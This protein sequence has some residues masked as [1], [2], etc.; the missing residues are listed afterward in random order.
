MLSV[1]NSATRLTA[2]APDRALLPVPEGTATRWLGWLVALCAVVAG[3]HAMSPSPVGVFYDDAMYVALGKAIAHG[4]GYAYANLP[5]APAAT[6]YPPIYPL[7]L[8]LLWRIAPNFPAN[9]VLFKLANVAFTAFAAVGAYVFGRR[10]LR[11]PAALAAL[12]AIVGAVALP[13]LYLT[14][15]VLSEPMFLALLIPVLLVSERMIEHEASLGHAFAVGAAIGALALVRTFGVLVAPALVVALVA[16]YRWRDALSMTL[17]AALVLAPWV[18][19]VHR[20][21]AL[22]P[23]VL[24]GAYGSYTGWLIE[25]TRSGGLEFVRRTVALNALTTWGIIARTFSPWPSPLLD[26]L[27]VTLLAALAVAGAVV[28]RRRVRVTL[29][30][31][32][33]YFAI[34]LIW[35]FPPIRFVANLWALLILLPI[36]GA[37]ALWRLAASRADKS[38]LRFLPA[39]AGGVVALGLLVLTVQGYGQS[40]WAGLA[41]F[42]GERIDPKTAWVARHTRSDDVIA[43]EDEVAVYLYT[44]RHAVPVY[45]SPGRQHIVPQTPAER[46]QAL[47]A[48]I[49]RYRPSFIV[50]GTDEGLAAVDA[51]AADSSF[52][53]RRAAEIPASLVYVSTRRPLPISR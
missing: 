49:D 41:R 48:I 40:A 6:H 33:L 45:A 13:S 47:S 12:G 24:R 35:P 46:K 27:F 28:E 7:F 32:G 36:T 16:R 15:M 21:D 22:I 31:L 26:A 42:Q 5:D 39:A 34:V 20:H 4:Q 17:G 29:V 2:G 19:W 44:G 10:R 18:W 30:F 8:A 11:L 43:T 38:R 50:V 14:S 51:F 52:A 25:S 37:C 53:F 1:S 3:I 23:P 9:I